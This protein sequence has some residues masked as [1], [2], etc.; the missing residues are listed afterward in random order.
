MVIPA[1]M[2][3]YRE[4]EQARI[5]SR[6]TRS[7]SEIDEYRESQTKETQPVRCAHRHQLV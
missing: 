4:S 5:L 1:D 7:M 2:C 6:G 3:G